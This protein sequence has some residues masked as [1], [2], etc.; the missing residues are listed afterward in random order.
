MNK[1]IKKLIES[2]YKFNPAD[3]EEE[4][5]DEVLNQAK[6]FIEPSIPELLYS[7]YNIDSIPNKWK[8]E[9]DPK[10][11]F[12]NLYYTYKDYWYGDLKHMPDVGKRLVS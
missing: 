11:G 7:L 12:I 9:K 6:K 4:L 10:S 8:T 1:A 3:Y 5:E 2:L